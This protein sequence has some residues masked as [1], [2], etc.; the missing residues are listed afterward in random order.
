MFE[1]YRRFPVSHLPRF[2]VLQVRRESEEPRIHTDF[3]HQAVGQRDIKYWTETRKNRGEAFVERRPVF[4]STR[5]TIS[6]GSNNGAIQHILTKEP[7]RSGQTVNEL[8]LSALSTDDSP[9]LLDLAEK[10][11]AFLKEAFRGQDR[12]VVDLLLDNLV[13]NDQGKIFPIDQEWCCRAGL[14]DPESMFCRGIV[15]F[16]SRNALTLDRLPA[17]R[18][19]GACHQDFMAHLCSVVGVA[20]DTAC[21]SVERFERLFRSG[22]L[23][24]YGV[25]EISSMLERR[26]G[27]QEAIQ[28]AAILGFAQGQSVSQIVVPFPAASGRMGCT[29][30]FRFPSS[31]DRAE[32]LSIVFPSWLG[33]P[34]IETLSLSNIVEGEETV[35]RDERD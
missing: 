33:A 31:P 7:Y 11:L 23:Q 18:Q 15:Y 20:A 25:I 4:E 19:W 16:L 8:W 32:S 9:T 14:L 35:L 29:F 22:T 26:F 12:A 30:Q 27:D 10:Y 1:E 6:T 2:E 17:A 13:V 24:Q 28:L 21:A 5:Q 34:R 3:I